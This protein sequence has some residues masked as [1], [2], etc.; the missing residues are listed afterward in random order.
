VVSGGGR[1]S[2]FVQSGGGSLPD[3]LSETGLF[4]SLTSL[5]PVSGFIEYEPNV[6]FWS[7]GSIKRRWVA[8]PDAG[9]VGFSPTGQWGFPLGTVILKHFE[10]EMVEGDAQSRKRLETRVLVNGSNEWF[11]FTYRW[12]DLG[13]EATLLAG[14]ES[15]ILSITEADGG[16]RLQQYDYPS[17]ADCL[18]CHNQAAGF[19]LSLVTRQHNGDFDYLLGTDNQLRAWNH[20]GL[21]DLDIGDSSQYEAYPQ[22]TD[23]S[24]D[25]EERARTY[26]A[27]NCGQ[28]HR[29]GGSTPVAIDLRFDTLRAAMG[30]VDELPQAG[31]LGIVDARIVAPGSK[32]TSVL[33]QRMSTLDQGQRMPPLGSHRLDETGITLIGEWID[34][35]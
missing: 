20:I 13:T 15:E 5:T 9:R 19:A 12:N 21:F 1:I 11:G 25:L 22:I 18:A 2:R 4:S 30:I 31:D 17:R 16:T 33:W 10:M 26:L 14:R 34:Q 3:T 23:S 35:L 27:V 29:P 7:D 32:E 6:P 28:C 8:I 24:A